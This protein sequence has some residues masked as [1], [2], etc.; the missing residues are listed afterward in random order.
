MA[1]ARFL[2][3]E[4]ERYKGRGRLKEIT[5][6][7]QRAYNAF[8]DS[9]IYSY[10]T[11]PELKVP[12]E[13][14]PV[15]EY[16]SSKGDA[17]AKAILGL[18]SS[19]TA[20]VNENVC[21]EIKYNPKGMIEPS[22]GLLTLQLGLDCILAERDYHT[23]PNLDLYLSRVMRIQGVGKLSFNACKGSSQKLEK[24][25]GRCNERAYWA[26]RG[27]SGVIQAMLQQGKVKQAYKLTRECIHLKPFM[28]DVFNTV[29]NQYNNLGFFKKI[30]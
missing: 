19:P 3:G 12:K 4:P 17:R 26:V 6:M 5:Q 11:L 14:K 13:L 10:I 22:E 18:L 29:E 1:H 8:Y 30:F 25:W 20:T 9:L 21:K 16:L 23:Y 27:L 24:V 28:Q 15:L 2:M 7:Y